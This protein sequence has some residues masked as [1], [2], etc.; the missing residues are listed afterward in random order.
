M[1]LFQKTFS[2]LGFKHV[3]PSFNYKYDRPTFCRVILERKLNLIF[4]LKKEKVLLTLSPLPAIIGN[5]K[6]SD[7][8]NS[9][10]CL[11]LKLEQNKAFFSV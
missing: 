3:T 2:A 7:G 10:L 11:S 5:W 9:G 8:L 6:S 4:C 1:I